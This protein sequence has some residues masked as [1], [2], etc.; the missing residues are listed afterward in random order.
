MSRIRRQQYQLYREKE[1]NYELGEENVEKATFFKKSD[2]MDRKSD[3]LMHS[4]FIWFSS[5]FVI[6]EHNLKG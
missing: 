5:D 4:V 6:L 3:G 2:S 1:Q